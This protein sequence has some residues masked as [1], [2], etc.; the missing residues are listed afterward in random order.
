MCRKVSAETE[1]AFYTVNTVRIRALTTPLG[2]IKQARHLEYAARA[3]FELCHRRPLPMN[4]IYGQMSN[5]P[6]LRTVTIP[7]DE[8]PQDGKKTVRSLS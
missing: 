6:K 8:L 5:F 4:I 2:S 7:C 3:A 1:E